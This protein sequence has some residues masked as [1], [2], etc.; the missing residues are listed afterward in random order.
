MTFLSCSTAQIT[1]YSS[2]FLIVVPGLPRLLSPYHLMRKD[3]AT[4]L[5]NLLHPRR[6]RTLPSPP[7]LLQSRTCSTLSLFTLPTR[8]QITATHLLTMQQVPLRQRRRRR[9]RR[10]PARHR[11]LP[12][13]P[14]ASSHAGVNPPRAHQRPSRP[15][16][17]PSPGLTTTTGAMGTA[18]RNLR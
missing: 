1:A 15:R 4:T 17:S 9:R 13:T 12:P 11:S 2:S 3:D 16:Q 7:I 6:L 5:D 14:Q 18:A 10:Q 8:N